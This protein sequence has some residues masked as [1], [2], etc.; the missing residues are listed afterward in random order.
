VTQVR[1]TVDKVSIRVLDPTGRV[2]AVVAARPPR[3]VVTTVPGPQGFKGDKGDKGDTGDTGPQGPQGVKGDQGIQGLT[4]PKG[5]KGDKGDTGDTGA[6]GPQGIQGIQG[7]TGPQGPQGVQ[8]ETGPQGP[9]GDTG[10]TGPQ[11]PQGDTGPQGIQGDTGPQGPQGDVGDP[12]VVIDSTPPTNTDLLWVDT[13]ETGEGL[14]L[15]DLADVDEGSGANTDD[16]LT[17]DGTMWVPMAIPTYSVLSDYVDPYSYIGI[18]VS[19]ST[20]SAAVWDISRIDT[21][22]PISVAYAY[23]VE[24]DDRLTSIY[25]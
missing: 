11:G 12:G 20:T 7:D 18:A 9:Q 6:Q 5:D 17:Y 24:W 4:G 10:A 21:T 3:S 14:S 13:S 15:G 8:G 2:K 23:D 19:G 22:P 25:S 1:P 16:V